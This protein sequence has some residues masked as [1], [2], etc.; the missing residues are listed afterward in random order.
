MENIIEVLILGNIGLTGVLLLYE[1]IRDKYLFETLGIE[2]DK[3][4]KKLNT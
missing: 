4:K 1:I 3:I 2:I